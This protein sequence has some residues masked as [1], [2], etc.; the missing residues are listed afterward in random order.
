[1]AFSIQVEVSYSCGVFTDGGTSLNLV[2]RCCQ[3]LSYVILGSCLLSL[4]LISSLILKAK[5]TY[6]ARLT[7]CHVTQLR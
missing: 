7:S 1:M 5:C 4:G 3:L 6:P 2:L